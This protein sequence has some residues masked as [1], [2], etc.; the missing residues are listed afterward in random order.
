MN[1]QTSATKVMKSNASVRI[2]SSR[3]PRRRLTAGTTGK[4]F[5]GHAHEH[6]MARPDR[7]NA[8]RGTN[9]A[10]ERSSSDTSSGEF[11]G[12]AEFPR[13]IGQAAPFVAYGDAQKIRHKCDE[14]CV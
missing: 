6:P 10:G 12:C 11:L 8:C 5:A 14:L 9:A 7:L 1:A 4:G 13:S 3:R 2:S